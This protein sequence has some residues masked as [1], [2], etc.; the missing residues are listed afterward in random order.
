MRA[1]IALAEAFGLQLVA[2]GVETE[3]AAMTCCATGV[4]GRRVLAVTPSCR[5]RHESLL[6]RRADTR[7]LF[8]SAKAVVW[9]PRLVE[10]GVQPTV[11]RTARGRRSLREWLRGRQFKPAEPAG[12]P[13]DQA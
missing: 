5:R 3:T 6:A 13:A 11:R 10:A 8:R 2:E 9:Q 7:A 1:I 12:G 4:T